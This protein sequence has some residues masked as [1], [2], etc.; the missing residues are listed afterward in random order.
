MTLKEILN[1]PTLMHGNF[2]R[3]RD[4]IA[5]IN[6]Y[7]FE[8]DKPYYEYYK[9]GDLRFNYVKRRITPD[10]VESLFDAAN[11]CFSIPDTVLSKIVSYIRMVECHHDQAQSSE[12]EEPKL[13]DVFH[14]GYLAHLS[15]M[16][17]RWTADD[18]GE[19]HPKYEKIVH[20]R[21]KEL[22]EYLYT[23]Y[24]ETNEQN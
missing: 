17:R 13:P 6:N 16:I 18:W 8:N 5:E 2:V 3:F 19:H 20:A 10:E 11:S 14:M 21:S 12:E 22:R 4:E 15:M 24:H 9:L 1:L 7:V 23:I